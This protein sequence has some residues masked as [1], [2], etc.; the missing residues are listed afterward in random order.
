M[1]IDLGSGYKAHILGV[2][3]VLISPTNVCQAA[4]WSD[5]DSEG[6]NVANP[7]LSVDQTCLQGSGSGTRIRDQET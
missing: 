4:G 3:I 2:M 5:G 6:G 7:H 1:L